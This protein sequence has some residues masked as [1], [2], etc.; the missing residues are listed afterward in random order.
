MSNQEVIYEV[1]DPVAI[2][3]L[4]RPE[5]LNAFTHDSLIE[6]RRAVNEA[7][8]DPRVVGI[9]I[10]GEGRGFC[11]GLDTEALEQTHSGSDETA[12]PARQSPPSD[13]VP[14]P[15]TYL[16]A[17]DKPVVAAVNGVAAG[18]GFVLACLC[19]VRFASSDA[20][21]TPIFSKRGLVP[22]FGVSWILPQLVGIGWTLDMLW[23]SRMVGAEEALRL[24][25][26][27][28]LTEPEDLL[29][30]ACDYVRELA[31]TVSPAA[32]RDAKRLVY[33]HAGA[34]YEQSMREA[35]AMTSDATARPDAYEGVRSFVERRPPEFERLGGKQD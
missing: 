25:L 33:R 29:E 19:D 7:R 35:D 11:S 14:G 8:D 22:E 12:G 26:V 32:M 31:T 30:K 34:G 10:T 6:L 28:H 2:I 3:R 13:G 27:Q 1:D 24:G 23:T 17:V 9:V 16:M 15:F 5:T 4:N 21:F 20:R 18:G